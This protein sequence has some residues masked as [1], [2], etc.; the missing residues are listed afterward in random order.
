MLTNGDVTARRDINSHLPVSL[1]S[2]NILVHILSL[3]AWHLRQTSRFYAES[4][5]RDQDRLSIRHISQVCYHWRFVAVGYP[6]LWCDIDLE[7]CAPE[8]AEELW[9]RS[10]E[11]L[12]TIW[13]HSNTKN[14]LDDT[15]ISQLRGLHAMA[16]FSTI[17]DI[18]H[19]LIMHPNV[20]TSQM[21]TLDIE[22]YGDHIFNN[23]PPS[24]STTLAL[25]IPTTLDCG[26]QQPR[27]KSLNLS[28]YITDF[29]PPCF[30]TYLF[31]P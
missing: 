31:S 21:E 23:I 9:L 27:L 10:R 16:S 22:Y 6:A 20:L 7:G 18:W 2:D 4:Y 24:Y 28:G 3:K 12:A 13:V 1:L 17:T 29:G 26:S 5:Y 14:K 30:P 11:S 15:R 25:E 19:K 8:W